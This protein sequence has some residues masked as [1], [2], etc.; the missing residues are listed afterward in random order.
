E[1]GR[2]LAVNVAVGLPPI[3][4]Q[5]RGDVRREPGLHRQGRWLLA[6]AGCCLLVDQSSP[7]SQ[8]RDRTLDRH[9]RHRWASVAQLY[10]PVTELRLRWN[11]MLAQV[12]RDGLRPDPQSVG[13][14]PARYGEA[15][16]RVEM[17]DHLRGTADHP[18]AGL[19]VP[20]GRV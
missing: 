15:A 1:P 2:N 13:A 10:D 6:E 9:G 20:Q 4:D 18:G 3:P 7:R 19:Q 12:V 17:V 11:A 14:V 5:D 16:L 8:R